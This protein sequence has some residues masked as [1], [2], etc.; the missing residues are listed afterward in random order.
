MQ[1]FSGRA[2]GADVRLDN[3]YALSVNPLVDF[4]ELY[5]INPD[6]ENMVFSSMKL[7]DM[8]VTK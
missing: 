2:R 3:G 4:C 7:R 6:G 5:L 8:V 1:I